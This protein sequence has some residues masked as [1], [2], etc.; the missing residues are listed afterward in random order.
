[1][2]SLAAA[3]A[4]FAAFA[5]SLVAPRWLDVPVQLV[6]PRVTRY[7]GRFIFATTITNL[8]CAAHFAAALFLS[9]NSGVPLGDYASLRISFGLVFALGANG[10]I[11]YYALDHFQPAQVQRRKVWAREYPF[12]E[13]MSHVKHCGLLVVIPYALLWTGRAPCAAECFLPVVLFGVVYT[14][15]SYAN[16]FATGAW[17]YTILDKTYSK[18]GHPGVVGTFVVIHAALMVTASIG[19]CISKLE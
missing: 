14:M 6:H 2:A 8:L 15:M 1:M 3:G 18:Y 12:V 10:T 4:G 17:Q 16:H 13:L 9:F 19:L 11:T 7:L 5:V